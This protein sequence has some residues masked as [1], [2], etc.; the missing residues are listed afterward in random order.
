MATK[1]EKKLA[2]VLAAITQRLSGQGYSGFD[3]DDPIIIG[4]QEE[5]REI[6]EEEESEPKKGKSADDRFYY[7]GVEALGMSDEE[8]A[9][10]DI[11]EFTVTYRGDVILRVYWDTTLRWIMQPSETGDSFSAAAERKFPSQA[12]ARSFLKKLA[13][14]ELADPGAFARKYYKTRPSVVMRRGL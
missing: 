11:C 9:G 4:L 12:Y 6:L 14:E 2:K 7:T 10:L 3:I 8:R 5:M 1:N 13:E